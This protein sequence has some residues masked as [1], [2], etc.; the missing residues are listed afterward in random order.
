MGK[1]QPFIH[2]KPANLVLK[3]SDKANSRGSASL[4][5]VKG[6]PRSSPSR[7]P[8]LKVNLN[9]FPGFIGHCSSR[10]NRRTNEDTYSINMLKLPASGPERNCIRNTDILDKKAYWDTQLPLKKSVLNLS[11]FD[12]HGS[13]RVAKLLAQELH[14]EIAG[15]LPSRDAFF[16]LLEEYKIKVGGKYWSKIYDKRKVYFHRFIAN[17]NTKQ[18]QIL[19]DTGNSGSRMIF[20]SW[21]NIIDKTSLLTENERLRLFTAFLNF[22]LKYC[23]DSDIARGLKNQDYKPIGGSTA[24]SVFITSYHEEDS[25]DESFFVSPEGLLKLV[26]TQVGDTKIVLCD[27]NGIAHSLT[28]IHH[29]TSFQESK[30]LETSF[31]TDSFG[32]TR[33]LDSFANTRSFG[34]S[35]GKQE[36]LS[37]E[38][39]IY[40]YL[41]GST[42]SLQRSEISKLQF[43]GDECFVCLITDGVSDLISDQEL[44]DLITS[45]VNLRGLKAASPQFVSEEVVRFI[46]AIGGR[47]ADNATC[48]ILRLPNWGNWPSI[49]RTGAIREE[50]LMAGFSGSE[51]ANV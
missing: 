9:K 19:F 36:G 11:V 48:L 24:S 7:T 37:C 18:E 38:P 35:V 31:Q 2:L 13:D 23:C 5:N 17:C 25:F 32:N 44:V 14:N 33:F 22:D 4:L 12:G 10:I 28:K 46:A 49:D 45:T 41:I 8:M 42:R 15:T 30:R 47:H 1:A 34:D 29:P 43:G 27:K 6:S 21:G 20:D 3:V 39:D 40:S 26:V 16:D 51:R 50:K